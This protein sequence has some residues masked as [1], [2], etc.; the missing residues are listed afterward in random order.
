M[1]AVSTSRP[2]SAR[3]PWPPLERSRDGRVVAG[4]AQG[5]ADHLGIDVLIVRVFF[6][7]TAVVGGAGVVLYGLLWLLMPPGDGSGA[8]RP[9]RGAPAPDRRWPTADAGLLLALAAVVLGA[10]LLLQTA[11]VISGSWLPVFVVLVGLALV[12]LRSDEQSRHRVMGQ[13]QRVGGDSNGGVRWLQLLVGV[14][15]VVVGMVAFLSS[16]GALNDA[17]RML[18]AVAVVLGGVVLLAAPWLLRLWRERDEERTAR[19]RT[20]ERAEVAAHVHDS[21]LQTLTLIQRSADDPSMV[22]KLARAQ[23]RDLR[24][25][26][27]TPVPGAEATLRGALAA[28]ASDVEATHGGTV[29]V[30]CV[31][32]LPLEDR[33]NALVAATREACVNA[34]RHGGGQ[35]S[36]Y[37][38]VTADEAV[39][40][41]RDRGPGFDPDAV[42]D[43][44]LG[45]RRSIVERMARVKGS[46]T[47]TSRVGEGTQVQLTLPR[48][49]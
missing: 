44:R 46:A 12:W 2:S 32:D 36:V 38:E 34:V 26:L 37:A 25:W 10:L 7:A 20:E 39:V 31:A 48:S 47:V 6:V 4:V 27:Y 29:D 28:L 42:P 15:L 35:V 19:I 11:G 30:V 13:V 14:G 21:V 17:G 40:Y 1:T 5:I 45:I 18:L 22:Q 9:A 16:R 24:Q 43:D 8:G 33:V 23:E 3:P 41:V 49:T